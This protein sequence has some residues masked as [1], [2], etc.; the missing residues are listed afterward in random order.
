[1]V[2]ENDYISKL[3]EKKDDT[4][5]IYK[6]DPLIKGHHIFE[7]LG[8]ELCLFYETRNIIIGLPLPSYNIYS[9]LDIVNRD[10]LAVAFPASL[11]WK[12]ISQFANKWILSES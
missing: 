9:Y 1:M 11:V 8:K 3:Q 6:L 4:Y 5:S 10:L 2:E 12:R 7:V